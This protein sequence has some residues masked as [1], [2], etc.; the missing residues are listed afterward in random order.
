LVQ[1]RIASHP[2]RTRS[3]PASSTIALGRLGYEW[4][5]SN[6]LARAFYARYGTEDI[7][8]ALEVA[9]PG[10]RPIV[11]TTRLCIKYE[12]GWCP[13]YKDRA[14]AKKMADPGGPLHLVNGQTTLLCEFDCEACVMRL[15]LES[16]G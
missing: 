11:M 4:N 16:S 2:R 1:E 14:P 15:T 12:L 9:R 10:P 7:E 8:P 6:S 5:V 3:K 13:I